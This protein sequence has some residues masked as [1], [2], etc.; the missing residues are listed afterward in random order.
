MWHFGPLARSRTSVCL[1][2]L[3]LSP[4]AVAQVQNG[5]ITGTV[6]DPSGAVV[7]G[8]KIVVQNL[9]T[10]YEIHLQDNAEGI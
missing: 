10:R 1:V 8:A 5:E 9:G 3:I 4:G 6:A 7:P 2:F